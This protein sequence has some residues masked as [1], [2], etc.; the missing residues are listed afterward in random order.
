MTDLTCA[1]IPLVFLKK[2]KIPVW[3]KIVI[4][5][6]MALGLVATASGMVRSVYLRHIMTSLDVIWESLKLA[7]YM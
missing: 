3:E 6:L 5:V 4:G 1:L 2:L 7:P